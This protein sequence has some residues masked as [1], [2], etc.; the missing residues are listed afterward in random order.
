MNTHSVKIADIIGVLE[1]AAP[2]ALQEDYDNSGLQLGDAGSVCSGVLLSVDVT[3]AVVAEAVANG[4]N[5]IVSHH[6]LL[7]KG[8][9]NITG[10]TDV[11]RC[12]TLA[13]KNDIA[14]YSAHTSLDNARGGVSFEMASMLGLS[15]CRPLEPLSGRFMKLVTYVPGSHADTVREAIFDAGAGRMG[16]YDSCSYNISGNGS[17]RALDGADPFVGS[18]GELHFEDEVRIE[19]IV[20]TWK[21]DA[22]E[23]ALIDSHP[24]EVP[25]YEFV[26]IENP[27]RSLGA[28]CVGNL[29]SPMIPAEFVDLVKARFVSPVARCTSVINT[30]RPVFKVALCGGSGGSLISRAVASGAD[31]YITSDT[32][33]HDFVDYSDKI[34]I[35][36]IGHHESESCT[37]QI[38][39]RLITDFFPNFAVRYAHTDLN[40]IN[41]V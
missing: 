17:F 41:Y 36:D 12:V 20:P 34:L 6:P 9:K 32:R 29:A 30:D 28:G 27:C 10:R 24:Y 26:R 31:A 22:V 11:E 35:V 1:Q 15:D 38:F 21:A 25:A 3:P 40:P 14:I 19:V 2:R 5:L 39:Y 4:C 8:L 18:I 37:K 7:F 33:Y 16:N 13:I 23:R